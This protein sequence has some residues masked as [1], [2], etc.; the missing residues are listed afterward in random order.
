MRLPAKVIASNL[1]SS[2]TKNSVDYLIKNRSVISKYRD[3]EDFVLREEV[4]TTQ[5]DA[6][7]KVLGACEH[8]LYQVRSKFANEL[9]S[10]ELFLGISVIDDLIFSSFAHTN[11]DNPIQH[12]LEVIRDSG[13]LEPGFVVYPLHS[14]GVLGAGL[15]GNSS[16][17]QFNV[18]DYGMIVTPQSNSFERTVSFL[19]D[20]AGALGVQREIPRDLVEHWIQSRPTKWL[21]RNP[22]L[23]LKTNS[24]PGGYYDNQFF[25]IYKL[26]IATTLL[27]MLNTFQNYQ[28]SK[29]GFLFDTSRTNNW[30]T[31]D[32]YH[33][34]LF[35]PKPNSEL[36]SGDCIPMNSNSVTLAEISAVPA[37]LDPKFWR[38][39][40]PWSSELIK[41]LDHVGQSYLKY[42]IGIPK[43]NPKS[44]VYRK[45]FRALE[46]YRK[47]FRATDHEGDAAVYLTTA[48][49]IMLTDTYGKGIAGRINKRAEMLLKGI[50]GSRKFKNAVGELYIARSKYVHAGE[51]SDGLDLKIARVAF[52]H[53][54]MSLCSK[55]GRCTFKG[56]EPIKCIIENT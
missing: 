11:E 13:V 33:Y 10:R 49:E 47:S 56:E 46:F 22:L 34:I 18:P 9:W 16:R 15:L 3:V 43:N 53:V 26:K 6:G 48:F 37:T 23:V 28:S 40:I 45:L 5:T 17:L 21:E 19:Q 41:T 50:K 52:V 25:L 1:L 38:K 35:Y 8:H 36:L 55:L 51:A 30:E 4:Y 32:I 12:A 42:S 14:L 7:K 39:R 44:R 20:A 24:F 31:L 27:L 29:E 2:K 54:F